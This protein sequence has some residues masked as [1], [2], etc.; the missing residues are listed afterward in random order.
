VSEALDDLANEVAQLAERVSDALF[1]A[2]RAQLR[3]DDAD[4]AKELERRLARVRRSLAKAEALLRGQ[5]E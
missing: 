4:A 3:D 5:A 1:G 2:V